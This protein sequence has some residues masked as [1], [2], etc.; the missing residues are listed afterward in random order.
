M[1]FDQDVMALNGLLLLARG[2]TV[3]PAVVARLESYRDTQGLLEP[4]RVHRVPS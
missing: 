1:T 3:T 4:I 2:Q